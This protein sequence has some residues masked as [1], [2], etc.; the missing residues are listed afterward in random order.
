MKL[1]KIGTW[2]SSTDRLSFLLSAD[3]MPNDFFSS[4]FLAAAMSA[5]VPIR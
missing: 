3:T 2:M 5:S 4:V 1:R